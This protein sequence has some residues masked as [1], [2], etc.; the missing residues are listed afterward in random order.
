MNHARKFRNHTEIQYCNTLFGESTFVPEIQ[1]TAEKQAQ[2]A[3]MIEDEYLQHRINN[4]PRRKQTTS[5]QKFEDWQFQ[6]KQAHI[7][8]NNSIINTIMSNLITILRRI[9]KPQFL[10]NFRKIRLHCRAW[11]QRINFNGEYEMNV[12]CSLR[13][14]S[15]V[16]EQLGLFLQSVMMLC[17]VLSQGLC[18]A[19]STSTHTTLHF[20][21]TQRLLLSPTVG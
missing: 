4:A 17:C 3:A 1:P 14:F 19:H 21:T 10:Y 15:I 20:H 16:E 6:E 18:W 13:Q 11:P 7:S 8:S 2:H 12:P 9:T 5:R